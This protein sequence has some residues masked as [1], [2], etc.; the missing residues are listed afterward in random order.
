MRTYKIGEVAKIVGIS[1][2]LIRYY[3][4]KGIVNPEKNAQNGYRYYDAWDINFL[5]D[6]VWYK[7][8]GFSIEEIVKIESEST[9]SSLLDR[10][11]AMEASMAAELH[12]R[13]LLLERIRIQRE[14]LKSI[15][16]ILG[17]CEIAQ[18][19]ELVYYLNRHNFDYESDSALHNLSRRWV[20]YMPFS[21][22]YFEVPG[23]RTAE[24]SYSWGFSLE[25]KYVQEFDV[26]VKPPIKFRPSVRTL[27]SAFKSSGKNA[28]SSKH[29]DYMYKYAKKHGLRPCGGA[30][31]TLVCSVLD[32][33]KLTGFFEVWLPIEEDA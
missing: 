25:P 8:F 10:L 33:G 12:R 15:I 27:H 30:Y 31:G 4:E 18:G 21:K 28:F 2:D 19:P 26:E 6:C 16:G 17:E 20:K 22:R 13:E 9:Y 32:N 1:T 5:I 24:S 23:N 14:S 29:I 7:N 11:D 3:E